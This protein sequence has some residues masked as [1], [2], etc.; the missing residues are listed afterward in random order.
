MINL[1]FQ[2]FFGSFLGPNVTKKDLKTTV[3]KVSQKYWMTRIPIFTNKIL[4][5]GQA[6]IAY[7][8]KHTWPFI[9]Y[10]KKGSKYG[11]MVFFDQIKNGIQVSQKMHF[12]GFFRTF[13][14]FRLQNFIWKPKSVLN[15]RPIYFLLTKLFIRVKESDF[16]RKK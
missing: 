14:F 11:F 2:N 9:W 5:N 1:I 6:D 13:R 8:Q 12:L 10:Q 16:F 3:S 4:T 7:A 15:G